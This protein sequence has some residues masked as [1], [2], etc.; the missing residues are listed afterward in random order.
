M[1]TILTLTLGIAFGLLGLLKVTGNSAMRQAFEAL[2]LGKKSRIAVGCIELFFGAAL[3]ASIA[4]PPLTFL[5][6]IPLLVIC[7]GAVL[8]H[9]SR[10]PRLRSAPAL[11]LGIGLVALGIANPLGLRIAMLP[12]ADPLPREL[13]EAELLVSF[14]AGSFL[15]SVAAAPDGAV[16]LTETVGA[17]MAT[18]DLSQA[19]A[20]VVRWNGPD[21][22]ETL[23]DL[24]PGNVAGVGVFGED[25]T[26][27]MTVTGAN[28]GIWR[29]GTDGGGAGSLVAAP[30]G[31]N[32]NG[33]TL[34]PDGQLYA[35]GDR[36]GAIWRI[37]PEAATAEPVLSDPALAPRRFVAL[38][39]GV[40]GVEF[41]GRDLI[42]TVS[43]SG[44][45]WS[46]T[47]S[48]DGTFTPLRL[49]GEGVPGDGIAITPAGEILVTT[50]PYNTVVKIGLD[51]SRTIIADDTT[52]ATGSTDL[53]LSPD[54]GSLYMV[55][56]GGL[57]GGV[58]DARGKLVR[59][60]LQ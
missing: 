36:D 32:W 11:V 51:G 21:T 24:P 52:Y 59:I 14:S 56:D 23:F 58:P 47:L 19:T 39:P 3:L 18:F 35:A 13:A 31:V 5:A 1:T 33:L 7:V 41:H 46:T 34:G 12:S 15:E 10:P 37:N 30:E 29:Y 55:T 28:T 57:F 50:H 22:E 38:A 45:I 60:S 42:M 40:N 6:V 44:Q 26:Y 4:I 54:G 16:W 53:A 48:D 9:L 2:G 27:Y 43:D 20:R 49:I 8:T 25:G 17:N